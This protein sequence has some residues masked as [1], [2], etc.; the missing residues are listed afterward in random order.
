MY[1]HLYTFELRSARKFSGFV[2]KKVQFADEQSIAEPV[3]LSNGRMT[4]NLRNPSNI[5]NPKYNDGTYYL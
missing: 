5:K 3:A 1:H 2:R 4:R